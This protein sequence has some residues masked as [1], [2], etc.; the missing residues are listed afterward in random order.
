MQVV[1]YVTPEGHNPHA[2]REEVLAE[3][4]IA[5]SQFIVGGAVQTVQGLHLKHEDK[6]V[7]RRYWKEG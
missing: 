1:Q 5:K 3:K 2:P 4:P 7:T 6:G